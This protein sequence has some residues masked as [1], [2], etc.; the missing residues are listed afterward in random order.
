MYGDE[1]SG[2]RPGCGYIALG[3][4][5]AVLGAVLLLV[6]ARRLGLEGNEV[7]YVGAGFLIA[8]LVPVALVVV[9][10]GLGVLWSPF[11]ALICARVAHTRGLESRK[12]A[13]A[14]AVYSLLFFWPWVYLIARMYGKSIPGAVI[15]GAYVLL[16]IVLWPA[17]A[18]SF[19][20]M[21]FSPQPY[22]MVALLLML[23][24]C[25]T[26]FVSK[27]RL[28]R[29]HSRHSHSRRD[30]LDMSDDV[31]PNREYVLPFVHVF[32]WI[33]VTVGFWWL[34]GFGTE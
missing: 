13:A 32:A 5:V 27:G 31:L 16:Y 9:W 1:K 19:I 7:A 11:A 18:L 17:S 24:C 10:F 34:S 8:L 15:R 12:Y 26:L 2:F 25:I 20:P 3:V 21:A 6:T 29:W 28:T 4:V 22:G 14:G 23:L 30:R 33:L